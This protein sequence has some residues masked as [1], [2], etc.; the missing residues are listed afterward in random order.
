VGY[1]T[2][3]L[4]D[5]TVD[6]NWKFTVVRKFLTDNGTAGRQYAIQ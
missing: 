6:T 1:K 5:M 4:S 2:F 3:Y